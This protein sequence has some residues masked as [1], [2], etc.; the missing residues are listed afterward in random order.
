M[1]ADRRPRKRSPRRSRLPCGRK[2]VERSAAIIWPAVL[3]SSPMSNCR[4]CWD[5]VCRKD[6]SSSTGI[7]QTSVPGVYCAGEPTGIGG[8]DKALVG[9]SNR[10]LCRRGQFGRGRPA[11]FRPRKDRARL[12]GRWRPRSRLRSELRELAA[13]ET[14]VCRCEDVTRGRLEPYRAWRAAKLHTRCG[15]GACQGRF[16]DRPRSFSSAGRSKPSAR[17]FSPQ[18]SA[19]WRRTIVQNE[20]ESS[21]TSFGLFKTNPS[22]SATKV[23]D[24][25]VSEDKLTADS[26][27]TWLA[28]PSSEMLVTMPQI[29]QI[30]LAIAADLIVVNV[31]SPERRAKQY[32]FSITE[33]RWM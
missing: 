5:A 31:L 24:K 21:G 17:R 3:V 18:I 13:P 32:K 15:M 9:R 19:S 25:I 30:H 29:E 10:G 1:L 11:F 7:K 33:N 8:V 23:P 2:N 16:A 28:R 12:G 22:R 6:S 27:A 4:D 26:S 14:I 20:Y